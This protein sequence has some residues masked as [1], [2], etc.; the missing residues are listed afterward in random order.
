MEDVI[1]NHEL[2]AV[3]TTLMK[4]DGSLHPCL[5]KS[6]LTTALE[7]LAAD[8]TH[9]E[10]TDILPDD[11]PSIV[12]DGMAVV[13]EMTVH[14][15][16][17]YN[18][19]DLAGVFVKSIDSK[20]RGYSDAYVIFDDYSVH[21]SLKDQTRNMRTAGRSAD[22][23]RIVEDRTPIKEFKTFL[24]SKE[25]KDNLTVYLAQKCIDGC[26]TA[27]TTHTRKGT[28]ST[29]AGMVSIT[30]TH[31]EADTLLVLYAVSVTE[32]GK[33]AHIYTHD[34]DVLVLALRRTPLIPQTIL[35]MGTGERR[36]K[37]QLKR[38][39]DALGPEKA[40]ALPGFHALSGADTTGHIYGKGKLTCFKIFTKTS[41]DVTHALAELGVGAS[42]SAAVFSGCEKFM[43]QL[44]NSTICKASQLRWHMFKQLKSNQGV[45][46]L[47]PTQGAMIEH[48]NRAHLQAHVWA[49][50]IVPRPELLDPITLGWSHEDG[51]RVP[52]VSKVLPAPEAVVELVR[53]T[54]VA[55]KCA[56]RCSCKAN[57]LACT[58]MCKCSASDDLC[59][60]TGTHETSDDENDDGVDT[61]EY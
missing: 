36:R 59:N 32:A 21:N 60:N 29:N 10:E 26:A 25:T 42:P 5:D 43:C 23:G 27:V 50:D 11:N 52:I 13:N 12:I 9:I 3:N 51:K 8:T 2:S 34:T 30:S 41:D 37:V 6:K 44:Y 19:K 57:L 47:P 24:A 33:V 16:N 18:C 55:S 61:C 7:E 20:S 4:A 56:G 54:C 48:T 53:C 28:K 49:Q 15:G 38:I 35:I 39:Y 22:R 46:K 58:D 17:I 14:K 40:A 1:G 31:E 45:E